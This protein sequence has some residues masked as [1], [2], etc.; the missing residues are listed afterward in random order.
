MGDKLVHHLLWERMRLGDKDAFFGLYKSLYYDLVNFGI[1][2]CGDSEIS[3]EAA[4]QVFITLWEKHEQLGR[5][6]NVPAYLRTFLK[7]KV[8]RLL[9]RKRKLDSALLNIGAEGVWQEMS[10]EEF[11][12]RVQTDEL[13]KYKLK[14]ALEKLT[15]RQKQLVHL[16]FFEGLSY[17]QI[18]EQSN[19]TIKTA[20]NTIYDALK[21]LRKE[22]KD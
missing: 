14:S 2:T 11:I 22:L 8:I 18:A 19:Q 1:R 12:I 3:G 6:D 20:Y 15:F 16:K 10:Y 13:M 9:E 4:D 17:E 5:V 7:R 21:V